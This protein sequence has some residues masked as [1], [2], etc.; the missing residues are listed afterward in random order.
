MPN[1]QSLEQVE[2]A[3]LTQTVDDGRVAADPFKLPAAS[4]TLL[5]VRLADLKAKDVAT[6]TSEGGRATASANL[7]AALDQ[8]Q[9]LLRDGYNFVQAWGALPSATPIGSG[10][11]RR[12]VGRA[13]WSATSTMRGSRR[14]RIRRSRSR[15]RL[16]MRRIGIRRRC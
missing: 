15:P 12:M 2:L 14:W 6:L 4:R 8:L 11:S 5:N 9:K 13:A 3:E 7:R 1:Q 10:C 16:P